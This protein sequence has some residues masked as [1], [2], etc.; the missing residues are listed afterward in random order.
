MSY[1]QCTRFWTTLDFDHEYL[2]KGSSNRQAENGVSNYDFS[3]FNENNLVNSGPLTKK[4]PWPITLKFKRVPA[5]HLFLEFF[6]VR[7]GS[8]ELQKLILQNFWS[9]TS[10]S[11]MPFP[12]PGTIEATYYQCS[13]CNMSLRLIGTVRAEPETVISRAWGQSPAKLNKLFQEDYW[14]ACFEINFSDRWD[15]LTVSS[16]IRESW[17]LWSYGT[18]A[19]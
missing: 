1:Q 13:K 9:I 3:A 19:L 5:G 7:S 16:I 2:W 4:W 17:R 18:M 12:S 15:G 11:Q 6:L 8:S 10:T 14:R